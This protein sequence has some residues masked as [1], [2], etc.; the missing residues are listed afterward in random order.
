MYLPVA[1]EAR[2]GTHTGQG[3][4]HDANCVPRAARRSR[5][6]V[7][8]RGC[9]A[10]P[11]RPVRIIAPYPA[12]GG[13][14]IVARVFADKFGEAFGRRFFVENR[15]GASG[16]LGAQM[17]AKAEPDGYTF[18]IGTPAETSVAKSVFKD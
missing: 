5:F 17:T 18:M 10:Q 6:G 14:D 7:R 16:T 11:Q 4:Q 13:V 15:T 12:G 1:N 8:I 3:V 2:A 9:P